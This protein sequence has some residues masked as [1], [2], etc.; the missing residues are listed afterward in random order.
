M[1]GN[2]TRCCSHYLISDGR[3]YQ[4]VESNKLVVAPAWRLVEGAATMGACLDPYEL[5]MARVPK[6]L[7]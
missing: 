1:R 3:C 2:A 7:G 5:G 4:V 6:E